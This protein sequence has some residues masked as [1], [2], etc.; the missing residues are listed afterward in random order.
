MVVPR[1]DPPTCGDV[2]VVVPGVVGKGP[3]DT[4]AVGVRKLKSPVRPTTVP[5]T[6]SGVLFMGG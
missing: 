1:P 3:N 6:T 5:A 4:D 2:V